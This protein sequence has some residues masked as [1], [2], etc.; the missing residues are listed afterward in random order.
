MERQDSQQPSNLRRVLTLDGCGLTGL[1]TLIVLNKL[2]DKIATLKGYKPKPAQLFD[3]IG[4]IGTGGW[5]ALLLGRFHLAIDEAIQEWIVLTKILSPLE[6]SPGGVRGL[7]RPRSLLDT[8][9]LIEHIADL[10]NRRR[11]DPFLLKFGGPACFVVAEDAGTI[12][13]RDN[14]LPLMVRRCRSSNRRYGMMRTYLYDDARTTLQGPVL[15][16]L[17]RISDAF[18]F[19]NAMKELTSPWVE[20]MTSNRLARFLNSPCDY[21]QD[22][23]VLAFDEMRRYYGPKAGLDILVNISPGAPSLWDINCL[24][25]RSRNQWPSAKTANDLY[26]PDQFYNI[27]A[28]R[29]MS[30]Q[31]HA[32]AT[33]IHVSELENRL[34]RSGQAASTIDTRESGP[35]LVENGCRGSGSSLDD[36]FT[37]QRKLPPTSRSPTA[38]KTSS[39][40]TLK[41]LDYTKFQDDS[42]EGSATRLFDALKGSPAPE[43]SGSALRPPFVSSPSHKLFKDLR[44]PQVESNVFKFGPKITLEETLLDELNNLDRI[45]AYTNAYLQ[46][47]L[48]DR[49]LGRLAELLAQ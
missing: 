23:M 34:T 19:T 47:P 3:V 26:A 5:I 2:L 8:N 41:G 38:L 32:D 22:I 11:T 49:E 45:K 42:P 4:G 15:P 36:P 6:T 37:E 40:S 48:V 46:Q 14:D 27:P 44:Y 18:C 28:M 25:E 35:R 39:S 33:P 24:K 16:A 12:F 9:R 17:S 29:E 43:G 13:K 1:G 21:S 7:F 31:H 10:A 30:P 20:N